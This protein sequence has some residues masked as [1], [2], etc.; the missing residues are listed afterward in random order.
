MKPK[1]SE[2]FSALGQEGDLSWE[3]SWPSVGTAAQSSELV[4]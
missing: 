1:T 2:V 3:P 4:E